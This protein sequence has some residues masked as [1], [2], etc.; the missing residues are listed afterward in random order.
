MPVHWVEYI[1]VERTS[2]ILV[3]DTDPNTTPADGASPTHKARASSWQERFA[4]HGLT[5]ENA[6]ARRSLFAAFMR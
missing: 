3:C 4:Q 1:P 6:V 2:D 5:P